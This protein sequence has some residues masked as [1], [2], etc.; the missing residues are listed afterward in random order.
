MLTGMPSGV[1]GLP[2]RLCSVRGL[3]TLSSPLWAQRR[4]PSSHSSLRPACGCLRLA[5]AWPRLRGAWPGLSAPSQLPPAWPLGRLG[6]RLHVLCNLPRLPGRVWGERPP[7][8]LSMSPL[9]PNLRQGSEAGI[10]GGQVCSRHSLIL[11]PFPESL[12]GGHH[13]GLLSQASEPRFTVIPPCPRLCPLS[14]TPSSSGPAAPGRLSFHLSYLSATRRTGREST[15]HITQETL[16]CLAGRV[17]CGR[18]SLAV[19]FGRVLHLAHRQQPKC[20]GAC[21]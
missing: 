5:Q 16:R 19:D 21:Q 10:Q 2:S 12:P 4:G 6:A 7:E 1:L 15:G 17:C 8:R 18:G 3:Q 9:L 11:L 20:S 13:I 14:P